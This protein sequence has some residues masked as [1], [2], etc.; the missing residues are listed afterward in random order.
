MKNSTRFIMIVSSLNLLVTA[1]I[2]RADSSPAVVLESVN[3]GAF[4]YGID[5]AV[6]ILVGQGV[7]LTGLSG[8]TGTSVI[9]SI[10]QCMLP[11]SFTSTS[12]TFVVGDG[13]GSCETFGPFLPDEGFVID[14]SVHTTGPVD[15]ALQISIGPDVGE[16]LTGSVEGPVGTAAMPEPSTLLLLGAAL[17]AFAVLRRKHRV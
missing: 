11:S 16:I 2:A 10:S 12:A 6:T 13:F 8:V 4:Q 3:N 9:G 5:S 14:S 7:T 17:P 15:W 1:Q